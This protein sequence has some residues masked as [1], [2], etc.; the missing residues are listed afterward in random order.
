MYC[1]LTT[2]YERCGMCLAIKGI[3]L[4]IVS[5]KRLFLNVPCMNRVMGNQMFPLLCP[6]SRPHIFV[7][8]IVLESVSL[9]Q[10]RMMPTKLYTSF[11]KTLA[12]R[13]GDMTLNH[14]TWSRR[15]WYQRNDIVLCHQLELSSNDISASLF[16][17]K[18]LLSMMYKE[19]ANFHCV[20]MCIAIF[21]KK[22][23]F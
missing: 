19:M 9:C 10:H 6:C 5:N 12:S 18:A 14:V 17:L 8:P 13:L 15:P 3:S 1:G 7:V 20:Y 11:C 23:G 4:Q 21:M 2:F 22:W 16:L